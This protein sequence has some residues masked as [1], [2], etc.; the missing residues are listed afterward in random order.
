M[1]WFAKKTTIKAPVVIP[2]TGQS[3]ESI[4][5]YGIDRSMPLSDEYKVTTSSRKFD[6]QMET[7]YKAKPKGNKFWEGAT[8]LQR[9]ADGKGL[10]ILANG[11]VIGYLREAA[12]ANHQPVIKQFARDPKGFRAVIDDDMTGLS[13][14]LFCPAK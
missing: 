2:R 11:L 8:V 4:S 1:A 12:L 13:V 10:E 9:R 5:K 3:K 7:L 14:R 6:E